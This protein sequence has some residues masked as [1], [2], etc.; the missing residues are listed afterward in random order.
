MVFGQVGG[1][2]Y[3]MRFKAFT[4][5]RVPLFDGS[6]IR[7]GHDFTPCRAVH[8]AG[9]IMRMP[10]GKKIRFMDTRPVEYRCQIPPPNST[11]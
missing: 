2:R 9:Y 4:R 3:S 8:R 1:I 7:R 11:V 6:I 10:P 5:G